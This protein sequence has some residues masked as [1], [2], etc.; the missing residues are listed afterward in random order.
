MFIDT[1]CHL[2]D[3]KYNNDRDEV[4]RRALSAG[5]GYIINV[6]SDLENSRNA[7]AIAEKYLNVYA[8][9]GLHP[10]DASSLDDKSFVEFKK[11]AKSPKVVAIGE[12]GLD[13]Y[14]N[15][16]PK[17]AQENAFKKF[18]ELAKELNLPVI[19]HSRDADMDTLKILKQQ[20]PKKGVM[21]CFSAGKEMLD[22]VLDMGLYIS[23]TCAVTFKN[24][25]NLR[26]LVKA[27]PIE[28]MMLETDAP[29]MAPQ[30]H[31]GERCEPAYVAIL[32]EEISRIKGLSVEDVG[33]IT[34][35]NAYN[36][37][38][39]G[40][41]MSK[42]EAKNTIAYK[43]RD[44]LY[45]NIT[46]ECTN[47]CSFCVRNFTDFVKGHHLRLTKEPTAQELIDAVG[48]PKRFKEVVFCGYG[49]PTER[50]DVVIAVSKALKEKSA[51]IRVVTN[52]H[53]N[54]INKGNI[55][56]KLKGIVDAMS[57]SLNVD[58]AEKY[59]KICRPDFGPDTY[60]K[61]KEFI[62]EAKKYIPSIEATCL[63][64]PGVDIPKCKEIATKELGV[65]IRVRKF[66]EVG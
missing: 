42:K 20:K 24:A 61:V 52:G 4:V 1:H 15:L 59:Y 63:D 50:I 33:R 12:V 26:Q 13:Y 21:H 41:H 3:P 5:V 7:V 28:R 16:S 40:E 35:L 39:V 6:G 34:S 29:Y 47:K 43:I 18:L 32:A 37:F 8:T 27:T 14:R 36:L 53:G 22:E 66:N 11:L 31:R 49:E 48:D 58:T 56:P 23:Y 45:L 54:L 62:I 46:N 60:N 38:G 9:V 17:A 51:N 44:S 25:D 64:M 10:H 57:V 19:I 65:D 55:L 2:D 30:Q